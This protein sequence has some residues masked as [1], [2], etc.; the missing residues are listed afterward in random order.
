[1]L[2][3]SLHFSIGLDP[4]KDRMW[5]GETF[6]GT[7]AQ[8]GLLLTFVLTSLFGARWPDGEI[9]RREG[10]TTIKY[11]TQIVKFC[12]FVFYTIFHNDLIFPCPES[13]VPNLQS[14]L[15]EPSFHLALLPSPSLP[16]SL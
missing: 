16:H 12:D 13:Y 3:V 1:M 6:A 15:L 2:L 7:E 9:R 14:W 5:K 11:G 4:A 8:S 10:K